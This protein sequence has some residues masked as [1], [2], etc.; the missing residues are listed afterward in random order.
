MAVVG[1]AYVIV[2][3]ITKNL[4][5]QIED[6]V[7]KGIDKAAPKLEKSSEKIGDS[8]GTGVTRG[9]DKSA[10]K[11][12]KSGRRAGDAVGD[13]FAARLRNRMS[14]LGDRAGAWFND[15]YNRRLS[16]RVRSW[17]NSLH[18]LL[19]NG[20]KAPMAA[21]GQRAANAF[22]THM[23]R[24]PSG[25]NKIG[26][27]IADGIKSIKI[28]GGLLVGGLALP[29]IGGALKI[30]GSYVAATISLVS[31]MGPAFAAAGLVGASSF[32]AMGTA[33]GAVM[34]AFK[35][36][37]P[38]LTRFKEVASATGKRWQAVGA[39]IQ[40]QLLPPLAA[41]M[42]RITDA[43]LPTMQARL[44]QTGRVVGGIALKF[45]AL[46]ENPLFQ[47]R[48]SNVMKGNNNALRSFG[49]AFVR[50]ADVALILLSAA[51]PLTEQFGRWVATLAGGVQAAAKTGESTGR[52]AAFMERAGKAAQ[53]WG[54]IFRNVF[55]AIWDTLKAA[56][57]S[58][59]TLVDRIEALTARWKAWTGSV[60]GKS[61]LSAWFQ[62][63]LPVVREVNGLI[64]DIF[65][66]LGASM[67]GNNGST[68]AFISSLRTEVLPT[69]VKIGKAF[70]NSGPG[71]SALLASLGDF[72]AAMGNSGALGAFSSTLQTVFDVLSKILR[73]PVIGFFAGWA[74]SIFGIL[75]ALSWI[76]GF[77]FLLGLLGDAL[78]WVG[79]IVLKYVVP[80]IW[81]LGKAFAGFLL[82]NPWILVVVAIVAGLVL[83]YKK[84]DWFR[85][86][87]DRIW[88]II[89][90]GALWLWD[91]LQVVWDWFR[92]S[93]LPVIKTVGETIWN[94]LVAAFET[95]G[96][97]ASAVFGWFQSTALPILKRVWDILSAVGS[98]IGGILVGYFKIWWGVV[99]WVFK[100]IVGAL[101]IVI[102]IFLTVW[103][104]VFEVA[105][106]VFQ[107]I[108]G[109][110][111]WVFQAIIGIAGIVLGVIVAIWQGIWSAAT[112]VWNAVWAVV[113]AVWTKIVA[114]VTVVGSFIGAIFQNVW[115]WA[116][117]WFGK[118]SGFVAG[119]WTSITSAIGKA[120]DPIRA[121]FQVVYDKVKGIWEGLTKA[122]EGVWSGVTG[123]IRTAFAG[124][125]GWINDNVI[126]KANWLIDKINSLPHLGDGIPH[127]PTLA[128]GGTVMAT[129][130]GQLAVL[131]E[132]GR[133]ERIEPLDSSGLS[134]RD[135]ALISMLAGGG[136]V[137][138][139][140]VFIGDQEL[141]GI[142]RVEVDRKEVAS[143]RSAVYSRMGVGTA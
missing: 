17:S 20:I 43:L 121:A 69:L 33:M 122:L 106:S 102:G 47:A 31:A 3:A 41:S 57:P 73:M 15:G 58:G 124:V 55:G 101:G 74:L 82:S 22:W 91:K 10:P 49:D 63:A 112:T 13:G 118:I 38:M 79:G 48:L 99:S 109:V 2:K 117:T 60:S 40:K 51:R 42:T 108:W 115:T 14:S 67:T 97:I 36:Q 7:N 5:R 62:S 105:S 29:A 139:V 94:I 83:M 71:F 52:L 125:K 85:A 56:A 95:L 93:A 135:R 35:A 72:F 18:R 37:T 75:K 32:L 104:K 111:S 65:K 78:Q 24:P 30:L 87:V 113:S 141:R 100:A 61:K 45:A 129:P 120:L 8:V 89:V 88:E 84:F 54:R 142:I 81:A 80:A 25:G 12:E 66:I 46:T 59:Q 70:S 86:F 134:Q 68:V 9:I 137:P 92:N 133:P 53:Q 4:D 130:G 114:G 26:T 103:G 110:V 16:G 140:R 21:L 131:A 126:A 44:S 116:T 23:A 96:S 11:L 64:G 76:P 50:L 39:S 128:A 136:G 27:A 107:A 119:V 143:S 28:P 98:F 1:T 34:L 77:K 19:Q 132:K 6:S 123:G 127:I 138:D 90:A